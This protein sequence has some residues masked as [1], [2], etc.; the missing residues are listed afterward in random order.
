MPACFRGSGIKQKIAGLIEAV[1]VMAGVMLRARASAMVGSET[2]ARGWD[3]QPLKRAPK[4]RR[5][6]APAE[7]LQMQHTMQQQQQRR[8]VGGGPTAAAELCGS[9]LPTFGQ[10]LYPPLLSVGLHIAV[11][12]CAAD[13]CVLQLLTDSAPAAS[14]AELNSDSGAA[15][16]AIC[17]Q[18]RSIRELW[19]RAETLTW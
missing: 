14:R 6:W 18:P 17:G 13:S 7:R 19:R 10:R 15:K 5:G 16:R 3:M 12:S 4:G 8:A 11:A 2:P 1:H 9:P